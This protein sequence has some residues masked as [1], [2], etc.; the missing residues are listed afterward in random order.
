M[1]FNEVKAGLT[2]CFNAFNK[3]LCVF[4]SYNLTKNAWASAHVINCLDHNPT[5]AMNLMCCLL[6][7]QNKQHTYHAPAITFCCGVVMP[8]SSTLCIVTHMHAMSFNLHPSESW[9]YRPIPNKQ[10]SLFL[11]SHRGILALVDWRKKG[12]GRNIGEDRDGM[13]KDGGIWVDV[14]GLEEE[15]WLGSMEEGEG[16]KES[17][18]GLGIFEE[19]GFKTKQ[20]K[21]NFLVGSI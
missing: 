5:C 14:V 1:F 15:G 2:A 8:Q 17:M 11:H 19:V 12:K 10:S 3:F 21:T 9:P 16:A 13:V 4:F 20:N 6:L 18:L 7:P